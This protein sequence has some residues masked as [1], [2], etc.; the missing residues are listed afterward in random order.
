MSSAAA[1]ASPPP[2]ETRRG[3]AEEGSSQGA[4]I[5]PRRVPRSSLRHILARALALIFASGRT[6]VPFVARASFPSFNI[7]CVHPCV[8]LSFAVWG[9]G[10]LGCW[11][12]GVVVRAPADP[13]LPRAPRL[14]L[15]LSALRS[16]GRG[17]RLHVTEIGR[18]DDVS[19]ARRRTSSPPECR[20]RRD[21]SV[22]S[23]PF[24]RRTRRGGASGRA[25]SAA[26]LRRALCVG[27]CRGARRR[28]L[29]GGLPL[30]R[31]PPGPR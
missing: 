20:R 9:R 23:P 10:V 13:A 1:R 19:G 6:S 4:R 18:D 8:G 28:E 5:P 11:G 2:R 12:G 27:A 29:R 14:P 25:S 15:L 7:P 31:S 16:R 26:G 21:R 17:G 24:P 30:Y 3:S 22:S